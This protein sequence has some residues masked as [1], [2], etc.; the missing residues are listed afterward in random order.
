[1]ITEWLGE[2]LRHYAVLFSVSCDFLTA[3]DCE[4]ASQQQC[5]NYL[6]ETDTNYTPAL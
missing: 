1:M 5:E 2:L 4:A 6:S 3:V